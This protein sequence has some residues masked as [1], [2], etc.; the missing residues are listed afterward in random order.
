[1]KPAKDRI[2]DVIKILKTGLKRMGSDKDIPEGSRYIQISD[3]L[4]KEICEC[5]REEDISY[6]VFDPAIFGDKQ[7]HK[8]A[9]EG[10]SGAVHVGAD[11]EED[12]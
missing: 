4:A 5:S 12:A 6:A 2:K 8:E 3:T 1:M 7:H 11:C 9:R 10:K